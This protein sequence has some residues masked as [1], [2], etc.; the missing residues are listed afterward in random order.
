MLDLLSL[1][2]RLWVQKN[3]EPREW[4]CGSLLY[5][6]DILELRERMER[7]GLYLK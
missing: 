6:G 4:W 2:A 3:I 7:S 1:R 5:R